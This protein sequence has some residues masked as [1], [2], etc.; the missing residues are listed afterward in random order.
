M[1]AVPVTEE[2]A[3]P[4]LLHYL[5]VERDSFPCFH[6]AQSITAR[7]LVKLGVP[8]F[9]LHV[10]HHDVSR[11]RI[12]AKNELVVGYLE[13]VPETGSLQ[14]HEVWSIPPRVLYFGMQ[15]CVNLRNKHSNI[16][17]TALAGRPT[18]LE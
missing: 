1:Y 6:A 15:A 2:L 13:E 16:R 10:P 14:D 9:D 5:T 3:A 4:W 8:R 18:M 11:K 7:F 17:P 12:A